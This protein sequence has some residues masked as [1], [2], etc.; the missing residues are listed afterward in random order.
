MSY[1]QLSFAMPSDESNPS[2]GDREV[3]MNGGNGNGDTYG[4]VFL[5]TSSLY[6]D[7]PPAVPGE[8]AEVCHCEDDIDNIPLATTDAR[9]ERRIHV[10]SW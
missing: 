4:C 9:F 5:G 1:S 2:V 7:E 10:D 3:M 6:R 8:K